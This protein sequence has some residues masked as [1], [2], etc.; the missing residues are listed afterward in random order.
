MWNASHRE[1]AASSQDSGIL[2]TAYVTAHVFQRMMGGS[3]ITATKEAAPISEQAGMSCKLV[4]VVPK[5]QK[6][7]SLIQVHD[8]ENEF[9]RENQTNSSHCK[10]VLKYMRRYTSR[11]LNHNCEV[12]GAC[13]TLYSPSTT[14]PTARVSYKQALEKIILRHALYICKQ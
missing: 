7:L 8:R 2:R 12:F 9:I 11:A 13:G 14:P 4:Y 6:M 5:E 10:F 1:D 3:A